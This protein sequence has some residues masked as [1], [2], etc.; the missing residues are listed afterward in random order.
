MTK[1]ER[2]EVEQ[3]LEI[4]EALYERCGYTAVQEIID[5]LRRLL[6]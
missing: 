6:K 2:Q 3:A 1:A 5:K 4:A